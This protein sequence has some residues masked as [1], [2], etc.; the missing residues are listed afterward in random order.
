MFNKINRKEK[1]RLK[2]IK[3]QKQLEEWKGKKHRANAFNVLNQILKNSYFQDVLVSELYC[4]SGTY[5]SGYHGHLLSLEKTD[6]DSVLLK[7]KDCYIPYSS[8]YTEDLINSAQY[9]N[10]NLADAYKALTLISY[11]ILNKEWGKGIWYSSWNK[12]EGFSYLIEHDEIASLTDDTLLSFNKIL[13]CIIS[14]EYSEYFGLLSETFFAE[15]NER[16]QK[17]MAVIKKRDL[18][19]LKNP[20][21]EARNKRRARS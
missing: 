3:K 12:Y 21:V 20:K 1:K 11:G 16:K 7:D 5:N 13:D 4:I 14:K 6:G 10:I 19:T 15:C 9:C 8:N 17:V 2:K 18:H